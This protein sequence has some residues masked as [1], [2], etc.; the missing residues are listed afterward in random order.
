VTDDE[1]WAFIRAAVA[2]TCDHIRALCNDDPV[3]S[4]LLAAI[5]AATFAAASDDKAAAR[6]VVVDI[7][8]DVISGRAFVDRKR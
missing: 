8:D 4:L 7:V 2:E 5:T 1:R 3:N 6:Q